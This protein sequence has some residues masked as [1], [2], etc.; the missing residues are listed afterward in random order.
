MSPEQITTIATAII[1]LVSAWKAHRSSQVST[2]NKTK[3]AEV[4]IVTKQV[5][6]LVNNK[7]A[8]L[9]EELASVWKRLADKT[10]D[11]AD[12][13]AAKAAQNRSQDHNAQQVALD[14]QEGKR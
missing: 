13:A 12:A 4:A 7:T 5:K 6:V 11:A 1:A 3:L 9:L 8:V 14:A 10:S 2:E